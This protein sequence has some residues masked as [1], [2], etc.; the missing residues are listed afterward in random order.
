[1][2]SAPRTGR[3]AL[4]AATGPLRVLGLQVELHA[5]QTEANLARAEALIRA[6]PGHR[7]YVLPELSSHGYCDEVLSQLGV[8]KMDQRV[9]IVGRLYQPHPALAARYR[10]WA[11]RPQERSASCSTAPSRSPSAST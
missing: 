1:M 7:L 4:L 8:A 6:N 5:G 10:P 3:M 11:T 2:A 9:R